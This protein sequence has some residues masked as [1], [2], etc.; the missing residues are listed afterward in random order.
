MTGRTRVERLEAG[1]APRERV[2]RW[3]EEAHRYPS[4]TA[5]VGSLLDQPAS[6]W[7]HNRLS[8]Q[9]AD[10]VRRTTRGLPDADVQHVVREALAE[11]V[12]MVELILVLNAAAEVWLRAALARCRLL[13]AQLPALVLEPLV[14]DAAGSGAA[15]V[16]LDERVRTWRQELQ[17]LVD[18][19]AVGEQARQ[20]LEQRY[21]DGHAALFPRPAERWQLVHAA[22]E[23]L[24]HAADELFPQGTDSADADDPANRS[25]TEQPADERAAAAGRE[26]AS[27]ADWA[28]S[29]AL[30][31]VGDERGAFATALAAAREAV[32]KGRRTRQ[33]R[34]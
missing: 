27:L 32:D 12:F 2:L 17:L 34:R 5:Y 14:P 29:A 7:P 11:V 18:E 20:I 24:A 13:D 15:T 9:A 8:A 28:R 25:R 33:R 31:Q 10:R 1:L 22:C 6:Q 21:L 16:P 19:M 4:L 3:L 23:D 26:A 30:G